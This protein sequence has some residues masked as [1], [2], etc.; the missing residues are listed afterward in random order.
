VLTRWQFVQNLSA[1]ISASFYPYGYID[2]PRKLND[3]HIQYA[4]DEESED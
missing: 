1:V 3:L 2:F 4:V